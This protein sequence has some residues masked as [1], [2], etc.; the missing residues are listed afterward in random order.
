M[1]RRARA[2]NN[3]RTVPAFLRSLAN[4]AASVGLVLAVF[5][6]GYYLGGQNLSLPIFDGEAAA[7]EPADLSEF[8]RVWQLIDKKFQPVGTTTVPTDSERV[9]GAIRGLVDSLGDPYSTY[10]SPKELDRFEDTLSGSLEG[11]GMELGKNDDGE[12]TVIA[13]LKGSPAERAGV[14]AG[15][16]VAEIDGEPAADLDVSEAVSRIRGKAGTTVGLTL[17]REDVEEPIEIVITR[18]RIRVPS[19]EAK[20]IS[21]GI[22][23]ISIAS[24]T[25]DLGE[26]F[27]DALAE[28][29]AT[30][31]DKVLLDLRGDPGGY[32]GGAVDVASWF[33]AAG[34]P[35]VRERSASEPSEVLRSKGREFFVRPKIAVL[36]D[37]GSAS[38]AEILAGALAERAGARI[39]GERT[40]GKGTVQELVDLPEG[41]AVKVTVAEWLTPAGKSISPDGLEPDVEVDDLSE[42]KEDEVRQAAVDYLLGK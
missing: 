14:K 28:A 8:L 1:R 18:E 9:E 19:V 5:A 21:G 24:F 30:P 6:S 37:R 16:I 35:V 42:T 25:D 32:L 11:V 39:F 27:E 10:L 34:E 15:D 29:K 36:V 17:L 2:C 40:F 3:A 13:P 33:L 38:A 22:L 41:G 23:E 12:L 26:Q 31:S 20:R 7:S 4:A